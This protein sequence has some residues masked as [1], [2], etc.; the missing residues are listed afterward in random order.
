MSSTQTANPADLEP[1]FRIPPRTSPGIL[2][3]DAGDTAG[4]TKARAASALD[5]GLAKLAELQERLW[6]ERR[7]KLLVVLQG[8][9][10]AG[11]G[12]AIEHVMGAFNP[13]GTVVS[14]FKVPSE[15]ELAHDYLWRIHG[16]TPG[17][18]EIAIWD[19]SHY[20][21][22]LVVRV[23]RLVPREVW[24]RRYRH[25][26]EFERLLADEGTTILKFFLHIDRDEQR[27]R[28]QARIEDPTKRWK[29]RIGDLEE[30]NRWDRYMA[31]YE[32][33]IARTSTAAAPWYVI[34]ANRK[35]FRNLAVAGI[36]QATLERLDPQYPEPEIPAD[37]VIE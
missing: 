30:R 34:P 37:L 17:K 11:K 8:M 24:A 20:E 2:E 26:V 14:S 9:D 25:I 4:W 31:A 10:T 27:E 33:A 5:A 16:R 1:A 21:D 22:V 29:F 32:A 15:M 13:G 36:L 23:K 18:G 7:H 35:W 6:A 28:L 3:R 19:R 12:G